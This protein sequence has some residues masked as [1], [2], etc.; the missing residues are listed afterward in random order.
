MTML[1]ENPD[2]LLLMMSVYLH[3][4]GA[5]EAEE[6]VY[7]HDYA[8]LFELCLENYSVFMKDNSEKSRDIF[9]RL[10]I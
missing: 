3:G 7:L 10:R 9:I 4:L 6:L 1:L 8:S 2:N 5:A